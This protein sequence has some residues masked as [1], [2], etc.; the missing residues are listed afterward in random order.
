MPSWSLSLSV[1][2]IATRS[3]RCDSCL[4]LISYSHLPLFL[5]LI[6]HCKRNNPTGLFGYLSYVTADVLSMSGI[7]SCLCCGLL[8]KRFGYPS[9]SRTP[10]PIVPNPNLDPN[11][12]PHQSDLSFGSPLTD[13]SISCDDID[14]STHTIEHGAK[15]IAGA[16]DALVFCYL[17]IMS[18]LHLFNGVEIWD[19]A[20]IGVALV[21]IMPL[22]YGERL[23]SGTICLVCEYVS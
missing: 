9:V 2:C 6:C 10:T 5:L 11:S 20:M 8:T 19:P 17:G 3:L 15:A 22:R 12:N 16:C 21:V 4:V 14:P 23:V 7:I 18:T 1:S 13:S